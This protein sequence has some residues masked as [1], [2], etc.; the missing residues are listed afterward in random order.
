MHWPSLIVASFVAVSTQ[1]TPPQPGTAEGVAALARGDYQQ[2]ADILKPIAE[3][4]RAADPMAQFFMATLYE[5]GQ[6]VPQDL[7]RA[8]ALYQHASWARDHPFGAQAGKLMK[9][10]F[11]SRGVEWFQDCQALANVGFE[12][13]F[14]PVNL[15]LTAGHSIAWDL[16]GAT[17][18]FQGKSTPVPMPLGTRGTVFFPVRQTDLASGNPGA[19]YR[20]F[21]EIFLWRPSAD[22]RSWDL[23][24]HLF[25]VV[26][27]QLMR[28]D[29]GPGPVAKFQFAEPPDWRFF[30]VRAYVDVRRTPDG[31]AE[32]VVLQGPRAGRGIIESRSK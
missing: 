11:R 5:T 24:W 27:D 26:R 1:Q 8:C 15:T 21:N 7:L 29:V 25:E 16:K 12:H 14:E 31:R 13:R 2:A 28:I 6:G 19:P 20:Y 3:G 17:I 32:W 4:W 10:L 9:A 30:D 23:E 22:R 18:T